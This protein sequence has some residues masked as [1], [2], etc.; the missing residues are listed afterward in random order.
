[1]DIALISKIISEFTHL[2]QVC[3]WMHGWARWP[4]FHHQMVRVCADACVPANFI[5]QKDFQCSTCVR[6]LGGR[7]KI[8]MS[9]LNSA[10]LSVKLAIFF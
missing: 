1:M 3:V 5:I 10:H 6:I 7:L 4:I 2:G 9:Y 8:S